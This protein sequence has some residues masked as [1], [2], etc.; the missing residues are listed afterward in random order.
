M[1]AKTYL[2]DT[3][4]QDDAKIDGRVPHGRL[5]PWTNAGRVATEPFSASDIAG[6]RPAAVLDAVQAAAV[7]AILDASNGGLVLGGKHA[8]PAGG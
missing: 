8:L 2:Q 5:T 4:G 6:E 7:E 1:G 3:D